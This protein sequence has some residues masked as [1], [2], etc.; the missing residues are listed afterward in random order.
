MTLAAVPPPP[1]GEAGLHAL[2]G[3]LQDGGDLKIAELAFVLFHVRLEIFLGHE[4]PAAAG[5]GK[6][7][8]RKWVRLRWTL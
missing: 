2:A 3:R 5:S 6:G 7:R 4:A 8:P 1:P